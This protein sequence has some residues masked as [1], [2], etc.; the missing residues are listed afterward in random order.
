MSTIRYAPTLSAM[1]RK[2]LQSMI[3]EYADAPATMSVGLCYRARFLGDVDKLAPAVVAL[4]RISLGVLVGKLRS[5]CSHDGRARVILGGD[6][7]D[8]RLL[9]FVLAADRAP[10]VRIGLA[11]VLRTAEHGRVDT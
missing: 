7:L 11:Q 5:L 4:L 2:R 1:S 10:D 6:Q 3:S 8:M 9:A